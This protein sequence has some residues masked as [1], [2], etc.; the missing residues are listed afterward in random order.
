MVVEHKLIR[1]YQLQGPLYAL[2]PAR[3]LGA[4][5]CQRR[6]AKK[7]TGLFHPKKKKRWELTKILCRQSPLLYSVY[8]PFLYLP[9]TLL[10]LVAFPALLSAY[11]LSATSL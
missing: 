2:V 9:V 11:D 4:L 3:Q 5:A 6:K 8:L 7:G 10:G 1:C